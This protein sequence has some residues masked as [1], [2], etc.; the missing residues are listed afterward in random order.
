MEYRHLGKSGLELSELS[1]GS[2]ITFG[3]SLQSDG[4]KKCIRTA[5]ENGINFFD[6]AEAYANGESEILMG[7]ALKDYPRDE[8]VI[9]T[10]IFWGGQKPNQ[11][12]LSRKHLIEGTKNSLK[13]LQLDYVDLIYCHRPD[14]KTPIEETVRAMDFLIKTGQA[15]YWGTSE[16]KASDIAAAFRIAKDIGATPPTME[17]PEYNL[18]HRNRVENE[19]M[20]LYSRYGLGT[21]CWSPLDSGILSGKYVHGIPEGSRLEM[22]QAMQER[23]TDD[24]LEQVKKLSVIAQDLDCTLAQLSIAWCLKNRHV[25]S[26]ILGAT[27]EKQLL[28]NLQAVGIKQQ[29]SKD[30]MQKIHEIFRKN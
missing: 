11:T 25:S 15:L 13:R 30:I 7:K 19:Y 24:K 17:Q 18:F 29:L 8:L 2:W 26:V 5:F 12:G 23:L 21:T 22:N 28:E 20:P 6:N 16:W 4:V 10:K 14:P 9:S 1:F 27:S 3:S